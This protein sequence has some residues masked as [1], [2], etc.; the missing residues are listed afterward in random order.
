M[1]VLRFF[2]PLVLTVCACLPVSIYADD[3]GKKTPHK[4]EGEAAPR[5]QPRLP[6]LTEEEN[7]KVLAAIKKSEKDPT[8]VKAKEELHK[9]QEEIK[10]LDPNEARPNI[11]EARKKYMDVVRAAAIKVDPSVEEL[12]KKSDAAR[13]KGL[14]K[15]PAPPPAKPD[16]K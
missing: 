5:R 14:E 16:K 13:S 10:K 4:E 15:Q 11:Q 8:V 7:K 9:V 3:G 1:K 12:F 2:F 6:G